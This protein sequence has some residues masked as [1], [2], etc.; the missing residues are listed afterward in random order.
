MIMVMQHGA[1]MAAE[2]A[3]TIK[4]ASKE[5]TA[6]VNHVLEMKVSNYIMQLDQTAFSDG[7]LRVG[8]AVNDLILAEIKK[9]SH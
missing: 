4:K 7:V 9:E 3:G 6:H 1:R 2:V 8:F 5:E